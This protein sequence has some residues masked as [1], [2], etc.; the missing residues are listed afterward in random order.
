MSRIEKIVNQCIFIVFG[1]QFVLCTV[2][3][4]LER[5]WSRDNTNAAYLHLGE[6]DYLLP[7]WLATWIAFF[8]LYNNF[9]PISLYVTIEMV[10]FAQALLVD[11]DAAMYDPTT[12]ALL[13]AVSPYT[14]RVLWR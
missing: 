6:L 9:I 7:T 2:S 14:A 12:G 4:I 10:N 8:I 11:K 5:L 3:T 1:T 13:G